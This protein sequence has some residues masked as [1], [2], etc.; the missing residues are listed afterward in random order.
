MRGILI[1]V[2]ATALLLGQ[3]YPAY[4]GGDELFDVYKLNVAGELLEH[5]V[6]DLNTDGHKDILRSLPPNQ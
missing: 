3:P 6:E 1:T 4:S 5:W 2:L